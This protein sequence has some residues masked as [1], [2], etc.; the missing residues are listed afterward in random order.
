MADRILR[1]SSDVDEFIK[2]L[3]SLK[4]PVTVNWQAGADRTGQ[5]NRLQWLWANEAAMQFGDRGAEDVQAEWKL[6]IGVPILRADDPEFRE[7]YDKA[8]RPLSY[9]R[10][11]AA[12]KLGFPVTSIMRVRQMVRYM[13]EVQR[14]S[15][16]MGLRLT[17][18]DP[19]LAQYQKRYREK[20]AA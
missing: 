9:E 8:I 5:Q 2:L 16:E 11:I 14:H 3:L 10:K 20:V 7:V 18:P 12:M 15:L 4:L 19:D 1:T 13:D 17:E 6:T